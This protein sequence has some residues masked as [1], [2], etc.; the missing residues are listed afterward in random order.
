MLIKVCILAETKTHYYV[1][2]KEI[3][4]ARKPSLRRYYVHRLFSCYHSVALCLRNNRECTMDY[5]DYELQQHEE[6]QRSWCDQCGEYNTDDWT[7]DCDSEDEIV[8][9]QIDLQK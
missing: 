1:Y 6:Q 5:L 7:C 8:R 2:K 3:H 9:R 4:L